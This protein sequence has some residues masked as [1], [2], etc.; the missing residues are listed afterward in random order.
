MPAGLVAAVYGG[1][2]VGRALVESDI[3]KGMFTG[4][5]DN[6]RRV[7]AALGARGI[8]AVAELSGFDPAIVLPDAPR[9]STVRA[10]TWAA[11]V[12]CGQTCVA[13]KR[14]Y[15]VGDPGPW[16]EAF[17]AQARALKVGDPARPETDVGPH[18][19]GAGP[20]PVRLA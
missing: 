16:A 9:Q 13:V 6:G 2:E 8:P 7:L 5:I 1:A 4:G 12:G 17:A 19:H 11:F 14:V 10:L 20:R 18:D 15:V 3:D